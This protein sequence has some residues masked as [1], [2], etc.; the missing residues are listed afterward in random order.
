MGLWKDLGVG[1]AFGQAAR[2]TVG[3][4]KKTFKQ[5]A[6]EGGISAAD[7]AFLKK[8][9]SG[10]NIPQWVKVAVLKRDKHRCRLCHRSL[11]RH[12]KLVEFDHIKPFSKGGK[13]TVNNVQVLCLACNRK[14]SDKLICKPFKTRK[15]KAHKRKRHRRS[16]SIFDIWG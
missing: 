11:S 15:K 13:N 3:G 2:Y 12:P 7:L 16:S 9:K 14:K 5:M 4:Y 6:K 10:R 1:K 8:V